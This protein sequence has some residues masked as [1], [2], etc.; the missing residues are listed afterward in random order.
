MNKITSDCIHKQRIN[1]FSLESG[2]Q[3]RYTISIISIRH[4]NNCVDWVTT[5][6]MQDRS[7]SLY[8]EMYSN[9]FIIIFKYSSKK[10]SNQE[11]N[12]EC[13]RRT[14]IRMWNGIPNGK[15]NIKKIE[16]PKRLCFFATVIVFW[17]G[18]TSK[19]ASLVIEYE[20]E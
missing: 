16:N 11:I 13:Q 8:T 12:I 4:N 18:K 20:R 19:L 14:H 2:I 9:Q 7:I 3:T 17:I 6:F 1:F 15:E 5:E 10:H